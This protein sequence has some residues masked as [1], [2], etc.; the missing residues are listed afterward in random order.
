MDANEIEIDRRNSGQSS[1]ETRLIADLKAGSEDAVRLLV[2]KNWGALVAI[3]E[4]ILSDRHHAEDVVQESLMRALAKIDSFQP[5]PTITAWLKRI[6]MNAAISSLRSQNRRRESPLHTINP[7]LDNGIRIPALTDLST[8]ST[9]D[10]VS[11]AQT[12]KQVTDTIATLPETL[13]IPLLLRDI[14]GYTTRETAEILELTEANLKIRL[15]R[16]RTAL[17]QSLQALWAGSH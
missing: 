7:E 16:A 11:N 17:R 6:V 12:R 1:A 15:H 3:A 14:E 10:L 8:K 9:E 4:L 5:R 13:R 2:E